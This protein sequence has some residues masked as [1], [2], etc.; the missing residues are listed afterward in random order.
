MDQLFDEIDEFNAINEESK[1]TP[2]PTAA[3]RMSVP[4]TP[5]GSRRGTIGQKAK[6]F[7][8]DLHNLQQKFS[9]MEDVAFDE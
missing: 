6:Q 1:I 4:Q 9:Q 2:T 3:D 5:G 7:N 8:T